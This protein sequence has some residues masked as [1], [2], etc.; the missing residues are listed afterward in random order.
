LFSTDGGKPSVTRPPRVVLDSTDLD[1]LFDA[2]GDRGFTVVGPTVRD[3]AIVLEE[4]EDAS[5]LPAGWRDDQ[6]AARYRLEKDESPRSFAARTGPHSWKRYLHPPRLTLSRLGPDGT[7]EAQVAPEHRAFFGVR[8]CDLAAIRKLDRVMAGGAVAD[9]AYVARRERVFIVAV[10]CTE[11]GGT[12]FCA[13]MGTG[14]EA[15]EGFDVALTEV[16]RDGSSFFV[17]EAGSAAGRDLLDAL[18]TR[19]AAEDEV[20]AAEESLGAARGRMGRTLDTTA[21]PERLRASRES[22]GWEEVAARCFGCASCTLVCPTCF[23]WTVEDTTDLQGAGATRTR[24]W[25]SCFGLDFSFIHGGSVR[26]SRAARY[27]H[28]ML[29]KLSTWHDQFAASGCV[30]CGRCITWCPAGIDITEEA[31]R[32]KAPPPGSAP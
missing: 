17:A 13:S 6:S 11:P 25:D 27:R 32:I 10:N 2:L 21:L 29:H 4:L 15:T 31:Q 9:P 20:R 28:W 3:G 14:P 8:P 30:G 24:R 16:V 1:R 5:L 7:P 26:T 22:A 12:C 19:P 23:C 18:P